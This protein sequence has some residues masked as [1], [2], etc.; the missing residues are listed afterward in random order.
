MARASRRLTAGLIAVPLDAFG[1]CFVWK[2]CVAVKGDYFEGKYAVVFF[3][4]VYFFV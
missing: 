4:H 1:D 2:M 3:F